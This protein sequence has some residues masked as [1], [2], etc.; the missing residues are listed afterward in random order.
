MHQRVSKQSALVVPAIGFLSLLYTGWDWF[1][2]LSIILGGALSLASYGTLAWAVK[3]FLGTEMGQPIIMGL[4]ILKITAIFVLLVVLAVFGLI[5]PVGIVIGFTAV[6]G[7][8]LKE[9]FLFARG[10]ARDA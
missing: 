10:E 6:L 3:K 9:G 8:V 7:I 4:S 2:C 5:H 1:L